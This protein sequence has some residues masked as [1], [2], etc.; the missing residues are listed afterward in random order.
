MFYSSVN[1]SEIQYSTQFYPYFVDYR[2]LIG[3]SFYTKGHIC[4][5]RMLWEKVFFT[6]GMQMQLITDEI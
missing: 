4:F 5:P 6:D 2:S 1:L 3:V